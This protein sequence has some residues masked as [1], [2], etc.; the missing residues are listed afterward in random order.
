MR[1]PDY[2]KDGNKLNFNPEDKEVLRQS[3]QKY[4]AT[5]PDGENINKKTPDLSNLRLQQTPEIHQGFTIRGLQ[6]E[7]NKAQKTDKSSV[8]DTMRQGDYL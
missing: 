1:S 2:I 3:V 6:G 7:L 8:N 5:N 4:L